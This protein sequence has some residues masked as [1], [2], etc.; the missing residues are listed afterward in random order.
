[1]SSVG[2][3]VCDVWMCLMCDVMCDFMMCVRCVEYGMWCVCDVI[4]R[5]VCV[6]CV[7]MRL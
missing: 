2:C 5:G 3:V 7:L 1:M 4:A 6:I